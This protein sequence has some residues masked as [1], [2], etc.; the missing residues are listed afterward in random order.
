[1]K[2]M[3]SDNVGGLIARV[4]EGDQ[5]AFSDLLAQYEPLIGGAIARYAAD[6]SRED[7]EDLHQ[8]ASM[9]LYR[10][11][12]RFDLSRE[13]VQFGLYAKI[14]V[15]NAILSQLRSWVQ[16]EEVLSLDQLEDTASGEDLVK[17]LMA[18]EASAALLGRIRAVLSSY[19]WRVWSLYTAGYR[20]GEIARLLDKPS[21]SVE[22]AV[23][24]IRQ[25]LRQALGDK[26]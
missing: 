6:R 9:A 11:A 15:S 16:N 12:M 25:K 14:C 8:V 24:R 19:E 22:N 2:A 7:V 10:A 23:Y 17:Q 3:Q 5:Q 1:M 13:G 4:R 26:R 18:E 20:S 21:H